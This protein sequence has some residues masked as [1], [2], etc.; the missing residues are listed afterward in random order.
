MFFSFF[1]NDEFDYHGG[2][3][4]H[5]MRSIIKHIDCSTKRH[6][7]KCTAGCATRVRGQSS[8]DSVQGGTQQSIYWKGDQARGP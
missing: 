2:L 8:L 3:S 6:L 5:N 1:Q 7:S 4:V